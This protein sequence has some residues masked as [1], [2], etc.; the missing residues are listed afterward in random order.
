GG[1]RRE[2]LPHL[3]RATALA[4]RHLPAHPK[5]A[6]TLAEIGRREEA[7]AAY[8]A[9]LAV[10][11]DDAALRLGATVAE[12][13]I[14]ADDAAHAERCRAEYAASLQGLEEFFAK[15]PATGAPAARARH[16]AEAVGSAQPFFLPYQGR[17]DAAPQARYGTIVAGIMGAAFPQWA[18]APAVPPPA[19]GEPIRVAIVSGHLWGHSV[20]KIPI[21]GWVSLMDR[22]RFHLYGYHVS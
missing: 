8:R 2:G 18:A 19:P 7:R 5:L 13:P 14:I 21:W 10:F 3:R 15:R 20:L 4:P 12:L 6:W 9:A 17:D 16:D 1:G 22:R 11:P